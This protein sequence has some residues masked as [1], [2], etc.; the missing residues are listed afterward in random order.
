MTAPKK[1]PVKKKAGKTKSGTPIVVHDKPRVWPWLLIGY[2]AVL[3]VGSLAGWKLQEDQ[4]DIEE[5]RRFDQ[6]R[7]YDL[8]VSG[9]ERTTIIKDAIRDVAVDGVEALITASNRSETEAR[10]PEEERKR[11]ES[12]RFYR[13]DTLRR[14]NTSLRELEP[15]NCEKL[16][17]LE[18]RKE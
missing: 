13:E 11:Q 2:A 12:I 8:C 16:Y 18:E 15:R 1:K 10:T 17:P 5:L 4:R 6:R 14:V 9:N 3:I 7:A